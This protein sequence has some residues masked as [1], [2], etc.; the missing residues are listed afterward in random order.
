VGKAVYVPFA[1]LAAAAY[2]AD[3]LI[4]ESHV[5]PKHG[6]GDDPKQALTPDVLAKVIRDA[7]SIHGMLRAHLEQMVRSAA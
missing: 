1:A 7:R 6:I 5:R 2:G 3:G 4:V